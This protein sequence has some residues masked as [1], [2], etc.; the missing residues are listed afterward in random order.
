M[1]NTSYLDD[2][3]NDPQVA[4]L[5]RI[6]A[7][8]DM[9]QGMPQ[10]HDMLDRF[11]L[12]YEPGVDA[13]A[14]ARPPEPMGPLPRE[15]M[16]P[17]EAVAPP[18]HVIAPPPEP[19]GPPPAPQQV[20]PEAD[21]ALLQLMQ[22]YPDLGPQ[23]AGM[24]R[25]V[26]A[27]DGS[28]LLTGRPKEGGF[29]PQSSGG[30]KGYLKR[31]LPNMITAGLQSL[32]TPSKYGGG[33]LDIAQ[34]VL[35]GQ[36]AIDARDDRA[37]K[38][39]RDKSSD[40]INAAKAKAEIDMH[41]AS[42]RHSDAS[43]EALKKNAETKQM[44]TTAEREY[45]EMIRYTPGTPEWL[46]HHDLWMEALHGRGPTA[47]KNLW[48]PVPNMPGVERNVETGETREFDAPLARAARVA[49]VRKMMGITNPSVW[50]EW[51]V[52]G[53]ANPTQQQYIMT[54]KWPAASSS[55]AHDSAGDFAW[56]STDSDPA[57]AKRGKAALNAM[58]EPRMDAAALRQMQREEAQNKSYLRMA[59][60][61]YQTA[62]AKA[63]HEF[64]TAMAALDKPGVRPET[65]DPKTPMIKSKVTW[66]EY[67]Q[68][69]D[70]LVAI[71]AE[72][73]NA[74]HRAHQGAQATYNP[75]GF[76][77]RPGYGPDAMPLPVP[78][79]VTDATAAA[80]LRTKRPGN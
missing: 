30:F 40:D 36:G 25:Q 26:D 65:A 8:A 46:R 29:V 41:E 54:G 31:A 20:S 75:E 76:K 6:Q 55:S 23:A 60:S 28:I 78:G 42:A 62:L 4:T 44:M 70:A 59:D 57:V 37:R 66:D 43:A 32:A 13:P 58:N 7:Q 21:P 18:P 73:K 24:P 14:P 33:P 17:P 50:P 63:E 56:M 35:A 11:R 10:A 67:N 3:L 61:A 12:P 15:M 64:K 19:V 51:A 77:P 45:E 80:Y 52:M 72:A 74:A 39:A 1:L 5:L 9:Q 69:K 38:I 22:R 47:A 53:K 27:P 71:L 79:E 68:R 49:D 2:I 48:R 34:A 16:G